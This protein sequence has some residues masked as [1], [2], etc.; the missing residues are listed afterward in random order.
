LHIVVASQVVE[1]SLDVDF[2]LMVTDLAPTD[3][4]LQRL[5]RLHRHDRA[6]PAPLTRPRCAVVGVEDWAGVPVRAVAGSRRVY[7][8][9]LLLRSAAQLLERESIALPAEIA[10]L[11]QRAYGPEPLGPGSWQTAMDRAAAEARVRAAKRVEAARAFLLDE[12]GS[13]RYS[14][15]G[16]V[17]A[18]VG[19]T[20]EDPRGV[21]QVRDGAESLEVLVV[22]GDGAGGVSTPDWID[23]GGGQPLPTDLPIDPAQAKVVAACALRLPVGMSHPGVDLDV[24]TALE[25]NHFPSFEASPLLRGQLVLVLGPDRTA[26]VK[27]GKADFRLVYNPREGLIHER[28]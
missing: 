27:H 20:D 18:G 4:L 28:R 26:I 11:V 1:Q 24:I 9:H 15:V 21:A 2:D 6:R 3:L 5:G 25:V 13:A 17:R 19:D 7:G 14:L 8:E 16:W 22:Q 23:R 12:V 10:P